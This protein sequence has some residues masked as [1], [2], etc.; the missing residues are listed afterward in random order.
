MVIFFG[1]KRREEEKSIVVDFAWCDHIF[2]KVSF[3]VKNETNGE[4]QCGKVEKKPRRKIYN[5]KDDGDGFHQDDI[6]HPLDQ[7]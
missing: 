6:A 5:E 2:L 4:K 3:N 7:R 1:S